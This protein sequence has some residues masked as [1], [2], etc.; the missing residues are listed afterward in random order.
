MHGGESGPRLR[1]S[2]AE[3]ALRRQREHLGSRGSTSVAEGA[4]WQ[5]RAL[6]QQREHFGSRGRFGGRSTSVA[7]GALR[8]QRTL[9]QQLELCMEA[10]VGNDI[11]EADAVHFKS[12]IK[13]QK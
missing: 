12:Y 10:L 13:N 9:R 11:D 8:Q 6:R 1:S 7:E 5:Q 4:L 2:V 3:G